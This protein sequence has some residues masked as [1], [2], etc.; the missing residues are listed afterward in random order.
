MKVLVLFYGLSLALVATPSAAKILG[1]NTGAESLT[2]ARIATLP[3]EKRGDWA[4]YLD[5]S[6][7]RLQGDRAT[8]AAEWTP[9]MIM[10]S[11]P[12]PAHQG[13]MPLDRPEAWYATAEARRIADN[14]VSFQTPAGGWSKNQDR[15][16]AGRLPGQ[17]YSNDA[18]NMN[19]DPADFDAPR[20]RFW[21]FAGTLDNGATHTELRFL[22]RVASAVP[23]PNSEVFRISFLRGIRYLLD[24]QYPNGG[25]PQNWPLEGGFHDAITFNDD[26]LAQAAIL[27]DEVGQGEGYFS[28]VPADLRAAAA[29]SAARAVKVVLASQVMVAGK[30]TCWPQQVD[31]LTLAPT[32]ARNYEPRSITSGESAD[33]LLFLMRQQHPNKAIQLA[34]RAC[35]SWLRDRAINGLAFKMTPQGRRSVQEP[36]AVIWSRNYDIAT[37][38]PIFGDRDKSIHDTVNE[39]SLERRNGYAWYGTAPLKAFA[40]Y[41]RWEVANGSPRQ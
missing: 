29:A 40:A 5:R 34:V 35:V 20:D 12:S 1:R 7:T 32:S 21:T 17:R 31:P 16:A 37:G 30:A 2:A 41:A 36:G 19:P 14:I 8:L 24:A 4:A 33:I 3:R 26:A 6:W 38:K 25:W 18:E 23:G 9:G 11:P 22:A 13:N 10:P 39:L 27:L 15:G 28:F